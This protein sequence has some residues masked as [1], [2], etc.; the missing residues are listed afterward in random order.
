MRRVPF[1]ILIA[2]LLL[3]G[4]T[5]TSVLALVYAGKV[6]IPAAEAAN[7][8]M[9]GQ[10]R[11]CA[12]L[13]GGVDAPVPAATGCLQEVLVQAVEDNRFDEMIAVQGELVG[14]RLFGACHSAGHL[15]GV[16]LARQFGVEASFDR[17]FQQKPVAEKDFVC[18]TGIVHGLVQGATLGDPPYDLPGLARQCTA[19]EQVHPSY[20]NECGHY[21]GHAVWRTVK[22]IDSR[23]AE[24]CGRLASASG[25]QS[26]L[27]CMGGAIMEKY[28]LQAA[29]YDPTGQR[30][31]LA[32]PPSYAEARGICKALRGSPESILD[33]CWGGAGWL[34]AMR[35]REVLSGL[36]MGTKKG[37]D[38]AF[39]EYQAALS[40]CDRGSC[41][42]N[43]I[44]HSR[45]ED[46]ENGTVAR[47]CASPGSAPKVDRPTLAA[48]CASALGMR[49]LP[50]APPA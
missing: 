3:A 28:D 10:L 6:D 25:S 36:D 26:D 44:E 20:A 21:F 1:P 38:A 47:V 9:E 41:A 39:N 24:E 30:G 46:F 14:M 16:Q 27:A 12:V 33:G 37:Q 22:A 13:Q 31:A 23:L 4:V 32:D 8:T 11:A 42:V 5:F 15:A 40:N 50:T 48:F 18:T 45:T 43:F 34:L 35:A 49:N 19:V 17:M 7:E 2:V 29:N